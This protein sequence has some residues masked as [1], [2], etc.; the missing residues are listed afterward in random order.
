MREEKSDLASDALA[1]LTSSAPPKPAAW[2]CTHK[3]R[4]YESL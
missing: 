3:P 4:E 1:R 2:K